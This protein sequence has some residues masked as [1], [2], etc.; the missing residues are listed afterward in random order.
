MEPTTH[1]C[2][3]GDCP[4]QVPH[5]RLMCPRHWRL[6]PPSLKR[7][8]YRAWHGGAGADSREHQRVIRAMR[9]LAPMMS[10][11][12]LG[13][14]GDYRVPDGGLHRQREDRVYYPTAAIV[15]E[16][17]SPD[18]EMWKKLDFYVA[19]RVDELLVVDPQART[20]QWFVLAGE[21]YQPIETSGL[22]ELGP[23][24]LAQQIDWP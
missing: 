2:P 12:N 19:H 20:V 17:V 5:E 24:E 23:S 8:L 6:V 16:I 1:R 18:D 3:I 10:I 21:Q 13:Q 4:A 7:A 11:F 9:C 22:I 15:V 14:P